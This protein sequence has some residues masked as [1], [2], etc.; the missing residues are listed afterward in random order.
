L[1]ACSKVSNISSTYGAFLK[2]FKKNSL[3]PLKLQE[4]DT[5]PLHDV[6]VTGMCNSVLNIE[7]VYGD[8]CYLDPPYNTRRYSTNY[9]VIESIEMIS[10]LEFIREGDL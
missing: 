4:I 10:Y 5:I 2:K 1:Y 9:F 7:E 3:V 6:N 8:L